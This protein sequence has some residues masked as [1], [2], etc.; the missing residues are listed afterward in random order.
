LLKEQILAILS[1]FFGVLALL[2]ACVGLYGLM[3]YT[4]ARRTAEIGI[5]S[6]LGAPR[7]Q[8]VWLVLRET[9]CLTVAGIAVGVP[10]ALWG[11]RYAKSL[12]FEVSAT[13]P[14]TMT[15]AIATLLCVAAIAGYVPV[16]RALRVDP[17]TALRYE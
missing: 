16:R 12:L 7:G 15:L 13:D 2:L 5:R 6:A 8:V 11:A 14:A 3:A 4:V 10:L 9:L 17:I 1:S